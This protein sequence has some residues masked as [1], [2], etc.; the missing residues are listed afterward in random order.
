MPAM[1]LA[2]SIE[3]AVGQGLDAIPQG[4]G[5]GRVRTRKG[6]GYVR[7][8]AAGCQLRPDGGGHAVRLR[9]RLAELYGAESSLE[10]PSDSAGIATTLEV[11]YERARGSV[12][13]SA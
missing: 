6:E 1:M 2:P 4:A 7:I 8:V 5:Y 3:H 10:S 12:T 11:P 9:D 13:P